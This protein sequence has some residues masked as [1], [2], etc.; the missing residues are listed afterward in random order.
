MFELNIVTPNKKLVEGAEM[1]VLKTLP[2]SKICIRIF[3]IEYNNKPLVKKE[4]SEFME[5]QGY[6]LVQDIAY[7]DLVF[8]RK[9]FE[10]DEICN[11]R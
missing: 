7:Q 6:T 10:T 8:E 1:K 5:L 3:T 4:M 2:F 9:T 11:Q